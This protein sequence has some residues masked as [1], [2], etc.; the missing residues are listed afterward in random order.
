MH[1]D[2]AAEQGTWLETVII[3][4]EKM[5]ELAAFYQEALELGPYERS[6]RHLGCR[7]GPVYFGFDQVEES[8]PAA[9]A[10]ATL[11]FTV[12][13][14][15]DTFDRLVKMGATVRYPPTE[16]PWGALLAAVYDPDGNMLGI[17]QRK[18]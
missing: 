16:K 3:F 2:N 17:S 1:V 5:E 4:T 6:P 18:V 9:N 8:Q 11:W 13:D 10:G 15:H 12:D 7:V 14:I